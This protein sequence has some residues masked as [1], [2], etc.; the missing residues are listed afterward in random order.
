MKDRQSKKL[1]NGYHYSPII[2]L[3]YTKERK[4]N[5]N[6][7]LTVIFI[8]FIVLQCSIDC[9]ETKKVKAEKVKDKVIH[10]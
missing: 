3:W 6:K 5:M 9:V 4:R 1:K 10:K 7:L 2:F 8:S